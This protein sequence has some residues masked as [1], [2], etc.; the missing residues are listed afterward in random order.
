MSTDRPSL[1]SSI[2]RRH[3]LRWGACGFGSLAISAMFGEENAAS[4]NNP[5]APKAPHFAPRAKRVIFLY[6]CGG[7]SHI[8]TFDPKPRLDKENGNPVP[9]QRSLTFSAQ[10]VNG[11]L[12]SP[13]PFQRF[14][15][16]GL[17]VSSLFPHMAQFADDLCVIRSMVGDGVDH[18]AALLQLHTG[19]FSFVRPSMGS[20]IVYGLGTENQNLPGYIT[21]KPTLAFGGAK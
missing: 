13:F 4:V 6:M 8:D 15:S 21:I 1:A 9:F 17:T 18:G 19:V 10:H 20:W 16:S 3:A 2:T 11:L 14:G 12:K 7:P 5:L